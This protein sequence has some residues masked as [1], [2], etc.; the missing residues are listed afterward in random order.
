M[1]LENSGMRTSRRA[2]LISALAA[3]ILL[4]SV[5]ALGATVKS[6][7]LKDAGAGTQ[8]IVEADAPIN[9]H[10]FTLESPD[11]I[12][13]DC[14][15][16]TLGFTEG[17]GAG[18]DNSPIKSVRATEMGWGKDTGSRI[19]IDLGKPTSYGVSAVGNTVVLAL[20]QAAPEPPPA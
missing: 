18:K 9:Y 14:P 17:T 7:T 20:E 10:D 12:V 1:R 2:G 19:V 11:R 3:G 5:P 4:T 8:V 13:L 15:G 6:I 16:S